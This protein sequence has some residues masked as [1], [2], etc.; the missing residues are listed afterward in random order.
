MEP[1]STDFLNAEMSAMNITDISSA[2]IR[3]ILALANRLEARLGDP[4]VHLEMGNP[5]LPASQIGIEAEHA[6][7]LQGIANQYPNISGIK[8]LKEN[9]SAFLKAFLDID[10][11]GRCIVPTV[12]SMQATFT[13]FLLLAQRIPGKDTILFLDP[14]FPA[15]H[16]QAKLLGIKQ[17]SV[18]I[19]DCRG[20]ALEARL[21]PLLAKGNITAIVY[22]N[23]NNPAW[24]NLTDTEYKV[25]ARLAEKH[26]VVIVEDHAYL[27]M[28][29]RV[30]Y[31]VPYT[32]PFV[33]TVAKYTSRCLLLVSASKIFSYAGQRIAVVC[34][35][36]ELYDR[37]YDYLERFYEMPAFG[38]AY[39]FGVLYCASSGVAHSAQYGF[40]EM[41]RAAVDGR[42]DFVK[43]AQEYG[44]RAALAKKAFTDNG[45]HIVYD[46]DG[47]RPIS[48]GF[49]FTVGYPG[50]TGSDLQRELMRY[51][52]STISLP[53][54]GSR[55]EGLRVCVSMLNDPDTFSRLEER[56]AAFHKNHPA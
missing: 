12:G 42:L 48:D 35:P 9:A 18:D 4:F 25:L 2:T 51:G 53:S 38:D 34:M 1:V 50:F 56:L 45:F 47:D 20:E 16:H 43:E 39:I 5:G 36:P 17:E 19:Y 11:P 3:Q 37:C 29:F 54:T 13:L 15:Q 8:P 6:A 55:Q 46:V 40:A 27:G 10:I 49:F 44:R 30:R 23:P 31:G 33:P 26:D 21:E 52:V 7:L 41:L 24:F 14:G 22:S 28:D 32:E